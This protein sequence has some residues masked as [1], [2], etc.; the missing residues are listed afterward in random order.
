M[1][2]FKQR[3]EHYPLYWQNI[4]IKSLK[5]T[6]KD[7]GIFQGLFGIDVSTQANLFDVFSVVGKQRLPLLWREMLKIDSIFATTVTCE[8]CIS[9][10]KH[11]I[12][13]NVKC[14]TLTAKVIDKLHDGL[15][16]KEC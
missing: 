11:T 16:I 3:F 8:Q 1:R 14:D 2:L 13:V 9:V 4:E 7:A 5:N 15:T 10:M 12:H 6:F